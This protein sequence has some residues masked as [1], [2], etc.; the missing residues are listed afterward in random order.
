[1]Y[2]IFSKYYDRFL[3]FMHSIAVILLCRIVLINLKYVN[4]KFNV[5]SQRK[6]T[7][8]GNARNR[9]PRQYIAYLLQIRVNVQ[10]LGTRTKLIVGRLQTKHNIINN[11][12]E[13]QIDT[14]PDT[15][16]A[17]FKTKQVKVPR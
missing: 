9:N 11:A 3:M 6:L 8:R 7:R 10:I 15:V 12:E 2:Y 4:I 13:Y 1:M 14:S 17:L 16:S 5:L